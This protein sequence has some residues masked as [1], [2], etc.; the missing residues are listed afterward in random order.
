M[1][2]IIS[3]ISAKP[4]ENN[5]TDLALVSINQGLDIG[6]WKD[7]NKEFGDLENQKVK[8]KFEKSILSPIKLLLKK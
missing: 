1:R 3:I 5:K 2:R 8:T 7:V 6:N 4:A